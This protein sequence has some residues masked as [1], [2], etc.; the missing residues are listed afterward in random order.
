MENKKNFVKKPSKGGTPASDIRMITI[1]V[2]KKP[3]V[4]KNLYSFKLLKT[5]KSKRKKT[6]KKYTSK[7]E[8]ITVFS[9]TRE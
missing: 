5:L 9:I 3:V 6:E 8:Y 1:V 2:L 7:E 4:L